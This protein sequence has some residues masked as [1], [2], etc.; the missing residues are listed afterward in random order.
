MFQFKSDPVKVAPQ[1]FGIYGYLRRVILNIFRLEPLI[2]STGLQKG[3]QK[4]EPE[5]TGICEGRKAGSGGYDDGF[6]SNCLLKYLA[7]LQL[8]LY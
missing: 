1:H 2:W 3:S 7:R 6:S 8:P 4:D 5:K